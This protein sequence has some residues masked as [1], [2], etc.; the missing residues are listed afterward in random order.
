MTDIAS[1]VWTITHCCSSFVFCPHRFFLLQ[2]SS[3]TSFKPFTC[4]THPRLYIS[5]SIPVHHAPGILSLRRKGSPRWASAPRRGHWQQR[6]LGRPVQRGAG[7]RAES[8]G[9]PVKG[10]DIC[11]LQLHFAASQLLVLPAEH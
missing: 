4:P 5:I 3:S 8:F 11:I 7:P 1:S 9:Q 6:Q 2:L 10:I